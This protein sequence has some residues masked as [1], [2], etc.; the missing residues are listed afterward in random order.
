MKYNNP[1]MMVKVG[2]PT[3]QAVIYKSES[4]KLHQAFNVAT[5]KDIIQGQP[6]KL[7][8]DGTIEGYKGTG[9]YLGIAMTNSKYPAYP[10][11]EVTVMMEGFAVIYGIS[12]G[13]IKASYVIPDKADPDEDS[14]YIK[15]NQGISTPFIALNTATEAGELIQILVK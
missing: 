1:Q 4:H 8:E 3:P 14:Q 11:D 9:V 2:M 13:E 15:Y 6:V 7:N 10:T 5:G 12:N